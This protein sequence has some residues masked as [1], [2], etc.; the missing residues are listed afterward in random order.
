MI[1]TPGELRGFPIDAARIKP[2]G[3]GLL[4]GTVQNRALPGYFDFRLDREF[5]DFATTHS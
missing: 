3:K 4:S 1:L 5:V 2:G